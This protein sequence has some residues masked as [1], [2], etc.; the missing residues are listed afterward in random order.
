MGLRARDLGRQQR[1]DT[2]WQTPNTVAGRVI[3]RVGNGG[4]RADIGKLAQALTPAGSTAQ[5]GR[6]HHADKKTGLHRISTQARK[7]A[8]SLQPLGRDD[9]NDFERMRINDHDLVLD[10]EVIESAVLRN[11]LHDFARQRYKVHTSRNSSSD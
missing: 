5:P 4:R 7:Y 2:D 8:F 10:E 3:D 6:C 1:L 9:R 11:D